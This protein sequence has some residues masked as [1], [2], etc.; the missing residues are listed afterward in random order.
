MDT[1]TFHVE[2][3][4]PVNNCILSSFSNFGGGG[5]AV[6]PLTLKGLKLCYVTVNSIPF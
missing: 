6:A 4:N 1:T 2:K 5:G 3:T